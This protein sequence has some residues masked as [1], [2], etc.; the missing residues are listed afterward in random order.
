[1]AENIVMLFVAVSGL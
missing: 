1:M